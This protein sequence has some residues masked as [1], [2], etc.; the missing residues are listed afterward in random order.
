MADTDD[1]DFVF[2]GLVENYIGVGLRRDPPQSLKTRQPAGSRLIEKEIEDGLDA[3]LNTPGA[4]RRRLSDLRKN[5]LKFGRG[6]GGKAQPQ[7]PCFAQIARIC[8][9]DANSRRAA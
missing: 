2:S 6:I 5:A 8:S 7:R 4:L 3:T 1:D 9:S